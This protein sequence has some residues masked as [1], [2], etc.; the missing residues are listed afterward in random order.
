MRKNALWYVGLFVFVAS[1]LM[2][3]YPGV[4]GWD[5]N[6]IWL[7]GMPLSQFAL[8]ALPICSLIGLWIMYMGDR[9]AIRKRIMEKRKT[10]TSSHVSSTSR[11]EGDER[12]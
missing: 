9:Q 8:L 4:L 6:D 11:K 1:V 5:R 3:A 10:G 7:L 2:F 12:C